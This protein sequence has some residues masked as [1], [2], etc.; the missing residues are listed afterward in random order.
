MRELMQM[1]LT[2][3]AGGMDIVDIPADGYGAGGGSGGGGGGGGGGDGGGG[4]ADRAALYNNYSYTGVDPMACSTSILFW[5][6]V[7]S[8]LG[9]IGGGV[10]GFLAGT[11]AGGYLG[12]R[13]TACVP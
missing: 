3:V 12:T 2:V 1:E 11:A 7:G 5:S 9:S 6:G 4:N 13:S 10:I 8:G